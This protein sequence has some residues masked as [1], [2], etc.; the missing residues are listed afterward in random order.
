M[1]TASPVLVENVKDENDLI[2][3][4]VFGV[5]N[6]IQACQT[7]KVKR[8]VLLS[9]VRAVGY[10]RPGEE[11]TNNCYSEKNW[12]DVKYDKSTAYTKS[13]VFAEKL[14]WEMLN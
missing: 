8:L 1:H 7:H 3:P 2:K 14:A 12:S 5:R 11:P 4:S 13:K 10:P 6:V 9:S